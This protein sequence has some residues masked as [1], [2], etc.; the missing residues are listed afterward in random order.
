MS[1]ASSACH[2]RSG[3]LLLRWILFGTPSGLLGREL[4]VQFGNELRVQ[5][6]NLRRRRGELFSL[7]R[8]SHHLFGRVRGFVQLEL[9]E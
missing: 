8:E 4:H 6:R 5:R 3:P 2:L 1:H 9:R 7:L